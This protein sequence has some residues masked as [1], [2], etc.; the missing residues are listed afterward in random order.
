MPNAP[1][2]RGGNKRN[3]S[4]YIPPTTGP[5]TPREI[6]QLL[7]NAGFSSVQAAGIMGNMVHES[8]LNP[9]SGGIDSNGAW[10]GGLISWNTAGY[11]NARSLVTGDPPA[12]VRAQIKYLLTSTSGLKAGTSGA[13]A[14]QVGAN[15]AQNVEVC[16]TCG[17]KNGL[18]TA[19]NGTTA[20]A[21]SAAAIYAAAKSGN[22]GVVS[23]SA[24]PGAGSTGAG[25]GA[26][27]PGGTGSNAAGGGTGACVLSFPSI[28]LK[29]TSIGGGCIFSKSQARAWIG[30]LMLVGGGLV[31][32]GGVAV[33]VATAFSS[34]KAGRAVAGTAGKVAGVAGKA[35]AVAK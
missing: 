1:G 16:S 24:L 20:R 23:S 9:E 2:P 4:S 13:T 18:P 5:V 29:V 17:P 11:T 7:L 25:G 26:A 15:F 8:G 10:A 28:D 12:D 34:T 31:T 22:W 30:A 14:S 19:P 21:A 27:A 32:F 3:P 35:A 6:Y 33:L